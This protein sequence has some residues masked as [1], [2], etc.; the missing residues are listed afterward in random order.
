MTSSTAILAGGTKKIEAVRSASWRE[1][2]IEDK[3]V[4]YAKIVGEALA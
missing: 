2:Y 1:Q 3:A 4:Y